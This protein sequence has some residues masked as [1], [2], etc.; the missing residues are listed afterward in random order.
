MRLGV[1][2]Y[3]GRCGSRIVEWAM[4]V[5]HRVTLRRGRGQDHLEE[6]PEV[7]VDVSHPAALASS[8]AFAVEHRLP[9]IVG[10]SG[11]QREAQELASRVPDLP[12][13]VLAPNLSVVNFAFRKLAQSFGHLLKALPARGEIVVLDRHP[14][15]KKERPSATSE[16][17]RDTLLRTRAAES[18]EIV[19]IRGGPKVS[20]HQLLVTFGHRESVRLE[21]DVV[22][23][24]GA[25]EGVG[26]VLEWLRKN[27]QRSGLVGIDEVFEDALQSASLEVTGQ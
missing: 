19:S 16:L 14:T 24:A 6:L 26:I 18:I 5:G 13:V 3:R 2:G 20:T 9:L 4:A 7:L 23:I 25:S 8:I 27:A 15:T 10:T 11:V 1:V 12:C 22:D 21:H 17:V